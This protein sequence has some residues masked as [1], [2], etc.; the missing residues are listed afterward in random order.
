M[1]YRALIVSYSCLRFIIESITVNCQLILR[2]LHFLYITQAV[3]FFY[4]LISKILISRYWLYSMINSILNRS[5]LPHHPYFRQNRVKQILLLLSFC[6]LLYFSRVLNFFSYHSNYI[7][8]DKQGESGDKYEKIFKM[9]G[10]NQD[11]IPTNFPILIK[12]QSL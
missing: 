12:I 9:S 8:G 5:R 10:Y 1:S 6:H 3:I 2:S 4:V 11:K 7:R